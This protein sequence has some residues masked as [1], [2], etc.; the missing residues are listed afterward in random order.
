MIIAHATLREFQAWALSA[1]PG[2]RNE[3]HRGFLARDR[4]KSTS[5]LVSGERKALSRLANRVYDL[6]SRGHLLLVQRKHGYLD[7]SYIAVR[8]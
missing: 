4:E 1:R 3:Y 5:P 7:Y 8:V 6:M 2:A